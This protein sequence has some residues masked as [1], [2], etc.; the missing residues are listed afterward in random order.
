MSTDSPRTLGY[1]R[2]LRLTGSDSRGPAPA[3]HRLLGFEGPRS[4]PV[5]DSAP[6]EIT[7]TADHSNSMNDPAVVK[8]CVILVAPGEHPPQPLMNLL[9]EDGGTPHELI[10]AEHPLIA[11]AQLGTLERGRRMRSAWAPA[12]AEQ[13]ILVVVNRDSW[14]DLSPLYGSIRQFMPAVG[15]WVCTERIAIEIYAGLGETAASG[16]TTATPEPS[17]EESGTSSG[18]PDPPLDST[19]GIELT[20]EERRDILGLREDLDRDPPGGGP[21]TP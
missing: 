15:I 14:R 8:R 18:S 9:G 16:P 19:D 21:S 11:L 1:R 2:F 13:T 6:S 20:D 5:L 7:V 10:R 3:P 12:Q 4:R 17:G